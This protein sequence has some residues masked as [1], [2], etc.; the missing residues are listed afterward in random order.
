MQ[1]KSFK[2]NK[3]ILNIKALNNTL[4]LRFF[5][6]RFYYSVSAI[7]IF[8]TGTGCKK[9]LDKEILGNYP[10]TEFYQ[11]QQ[12][13]VL[14]INAAY[15]PLAFYTPQNRL[16]VF[17][18]VASD[19]AAKG[20]N[21]G[22]QADIGLIDDFNITPI[23]GNLED[24]W[25]LLYEGV[26]R[27]NIVLAKVPPISMDAT[28][29]ARILAEAK[30]LRSWYY[31][32]LINI[33]G[34]VPLV[35]TPLNADQLQ[36]PQ[37]PMTTIFESVIEPDLID[38]A[39]HLA[40]AYAGADVG[41]A[42]SGAATALLAKAYLFQKKWDQAASAANQV[43]SS[44][45]Y[46]LMPVY[47]QNFNVNFKNNSESVF[48]FQHLSGQVPFTG[49]VLNQ[50]FAPA[51]DGGYYFDAPTQDFVDEFEK[52]SSGLYDPRL[53][54]T[55]GRDSMPWFNGEIFSKDWSP[56]GY[57][58]KKYQQ[59]FSEISKALKGDGSVDYMAIRYADVLLWYA[60]ALNELGRS[61]E[62]LI[63]LN[64]V[65]KRARESYLYD[66][67]LPG[68]GTVPDGLLPD[69]TVTGQDDLRQAIR[70]ER[71]VELGFEFHRYFDII[72]YGDTYAIQ[73]LLDKPNFNY[74]INQ[75]FPIPQSE[76]DRNHAL[77]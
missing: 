59:P 63:P 68:Y 5:L 55:V 62:A 19:D 11:T 33:F 31:F 25:A 21:A 73:A 47:N 24:E 8:F 60:E 56:T 51:V 4:Y 27:C 74:S 40:P 38:A 12:Q 28:L 10:E 20:G 3:P 36:V 58:T 77:H 49:N 54:Y 37:S 13:A 66:T 53:D 18:D 69:V 57:L 6:K 65:R 39:M 50:W 32:T 7:L 71:R 75:H 70:H 16:W 26:T 2:I 30:F 1:L 17:G 34:D 35:L 44:G 22:D 29:Q 14:A 67:F 15:Q 48:E 72:R 52:T 45:I 76:R 46:S 41:R 43:I 64:E 61:A 42:T 23:N 9:F